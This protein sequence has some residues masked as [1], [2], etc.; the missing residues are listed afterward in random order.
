M[1]TLA[2]LSFWLPPDYSDASTASLARQFKPLV[3]KYGL[4]CCVPKIDRS[5]IEGVHHFFF[6]V[7]SPAEAAAIA[8]ALTHD[9]DWQERWK[10]VDDLDKDA[11]IPQYYF[12]L[13][14]TPARPG[15]VADAG[16]GTRRKDWHAFS[17]RDGLPS[18]FIT[19]VLQDRKGS[20]WAS[21][22]DGLCRYDGAQFEYFTVDDGLAGN[23]VFCLLEDRQGRIWAGTGDWSSQEGRGVSCY[24]GETWLTFTR[25]DGLA[26]N[27]VRTLLEDRQGNLWLGTKKGLSR[28]D[29]RCFTTYT[30][31]DGLPSGGAYAYL[32]DRQGRL[33]LGTEHGVGCFDGRQCTIYTEDD[34]LVDTK[35]HSIFTKTVRA[36]CGWPLPVAGIHSTLNRRPLPLNWGWPIALM[37]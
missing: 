12:G 23:Q 5:Q 24:D 20:I 1:T 22:M 13:V 16:P 19:T 18:P 8:N 17:L 34:G 32:E 28:Y 26:G 36:A 6:D 14:S 27:V 15:K 7:G 10:V 31:Q 30:E 35:V 11:A 25:A 2:R 33:W 3:K 9:V 37:Q 21:S 29:G 4:T